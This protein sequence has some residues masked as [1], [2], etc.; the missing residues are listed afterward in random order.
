M[1]LVLSKLNRL[2][3][4]QGL[5]YTYLRRSEINVVCCNVTV[6][7]AHVWTP[8]PPLLP[9]MC[10]RNVR[11]VIWVIMHVK[12]KTGG[13]FVK[14]PCSKLKMSSCPACGTFSSM[15]SDKIFNKRARRNVLTGTL[16][17][18]S[19]TGIKDHFLSLS[20]LHGLTAACRSCQSSFECNI[21]NRRA[22][23]S[24]IERSSIVGRTP[25]CC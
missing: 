7:G 13:S 16:N 5:W 11:T 25:T 23:D 22:Q 21:R 3:K 6:G 19:A 12:Y 24:M 15:N 4:K 14:T 20:S 1:F 10:L 17:R 2:W 8:A 18:K 9:F